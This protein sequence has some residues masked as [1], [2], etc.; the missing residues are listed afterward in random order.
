MYFRFEIL[1]FV[2]DTLVPCIFFFL[3]KYFYYLQIFLIDFDGVGVVRFIINKH[4]MCNNYV[5]ILCF[6]C[7]MCALVL[8]YLVSYNKYKM[9]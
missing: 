6:F 5:C 2:N 8:R 9:F 1:Y 3:N 7:K 4:Y